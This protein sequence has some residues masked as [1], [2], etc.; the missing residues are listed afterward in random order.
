MAKSVESFGHGSVLEN[1]C[2]ILVCSGGEELTSE[3]QKYNP[4]HL[5][6]V[7][8]TH[9]HKLLSYI[10]STENI[11]A[12]EVAIKMPCDVMT[13]DLDSDQTLL[14]FAIDMFT[15]SPSEESASILRVLLQHPSSHN[16]TPKECI[17]IDKV[18][19]PYRTIEAVN[20][21]SKMVVWSALDEE[22]HLCIDTALSSTPEDKAEMAVKTALITW[23]ETNH[24]T[25][26]MVNE[27]YTYIA[28][29][30]RGDIVERAL[31]EYIS[32]PVV[33]GLEVIFEEREEQVWLEVHLE[34]YE[35]DLNAQFCYM[36]QL[37]K[38]GEI[39]DDPAKLAI[40][41]VWLQEAS[42]QANTA[43]LSPTNMEKLHS[44]LEL[45]H[46]DSDGG[47]SVLDSTTELAGDCDT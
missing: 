46:D 25:L 22:L 43:D 45:A 31:Q 24:I 30:K 36:R 44:R 11:R 33:Y 23:I 13:V 1:C 12:L 39:Q 20:E 47:S 21:L 29:E 35:E 16:L 9:F 28:Q 26:S 37:L 40:L 42:S 34:K 4:S 19:Q 8:K 6:S 7:H 27:L 38:S 41:Q 5:A 17:A 10:I 2:T 15:G 18:C 3:M 32:N 14:S